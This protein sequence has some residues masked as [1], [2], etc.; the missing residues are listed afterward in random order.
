MIAGYVRVSTQRQADEGVS[1]EMQQQMIIRHAKM[2]EMIENDHEITFYIDDGYSGSTLER[3]E[4]K[5]LIRDIK[6]KRVNVVIAYDLSRISR[7]IFDSNKFLNMSDKYEVVI[8]CLYDDVN[9]TTATS[10]FGTN[11]KIL[12]NQYEREK[13]IERTNDSLQSIADSG[14][15]PCGGRPTYGYTR[16][17]DK[18][19]Y[20]NE[21]QA[22]VV[23]RVFDMAVRGYD[24][25][26]IIDYIRG[27]TNEVKAYE[28]TIMR[29]LKNIRY[30]GELEFKGKIYNNL[31]PAIVDEATF[32][33]ANY[34]FRK[35]KPNKDSNYIFDGRVVCSSCNTILRCYQGN[36]GQG[37]KYYYYICNDCKKRISQVK[38]EKQFIELDKNT[39]SF[40]LYRD[41]LMSRRRNLRVKIGKVNEKYQIDEIEDDEYYRLAVILDKQL[42]DLNRKIESMGTVK[43]E[44]WWDNKRKADYI[45]ARV[46]YIVFELTKIEIKNIKYN[47]YVE[48]EDD[49]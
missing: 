38:L 2:L 24:M 10:R 20:I 14:R 23:K 17:S 13:I 28:D 5:K 3:P 47:D 27:A 4:M 19:L 37:K 1:I 30:K 22:T 41:K 49:K 40:K 33:K 45:R 46:N 12:T 43:F 15:Y 32:R 48:C 18:N 11:I 35:M 26:D 36:N 25:S 34:N 42:E 7:D 6:S 29:M 9:I 44:E 16:G 39:N 8:K 21:E 31:V